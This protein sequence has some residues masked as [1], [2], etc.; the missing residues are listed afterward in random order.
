MALLSEMTTIDRQIIMSKNQ[1]KVDM[2]GIT[3]GISYAAQTPW[4]RHQSIKD[5]ILFDSPYDQERYDTVVESCALKPNLAVLEDGDTTE[6]GARCAD[7]ST[8]WRWYLIVFSGA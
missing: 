3:Q 6:I 2:Y 7:I 5:N 8:V 1:R 4:L